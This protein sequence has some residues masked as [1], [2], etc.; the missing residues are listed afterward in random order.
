MNQA[1]VTRAT[2]GRL[3]MYL[4]YLRSLDLSAAPNTS[5]TIIAKALGLG[6]VQVRKDL[7]SVSG[8]G[9][10]KIGYVTSELIEKLECFL[11]LNE[12]AKAVIVGAGKLGS[13]LHEYNGF[14]KYGI[15][16]V[17]AFDKNP[18]NEVSSADGKTVLSMS[19]LTSFCQKEGVRIGIITVPVSAAQEVC[20][21]LVESGIC[22]IWNFAPIALSVPEGVIVKQENLALSLAYLNEQL[23]FQL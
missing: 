5:A 17:A 9:K 14:V 20:D 11:G 12:H 18:E 4:E 10:P 7:S 2:L 3:P 13:A 22:A 15:D 8:D 19:K 1:S 16:I 6:E 21:K 23:R